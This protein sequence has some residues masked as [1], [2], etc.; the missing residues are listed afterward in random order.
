VIEWVFYE[1][2]VINMIGENIRKAGFYLTDFLKGSPVAQHY[3][4][5]DDKMNGRKDS[6]DVMPDLLKYVKANIPYY[7]Y[8]DNLELLNFP[9]VKKSDMVADFDAFQSPE[10]AETDLHWV[11]TSGT[12]GMPFK[13]S[14]NPDKRNRTIADLIYFH[15][16]AGWDVGDRYVFLRAWTSDYIVH[17]SKM[18]IQNFIPFDLI[19]FDDEAKEA[20]KQILVTDKKVKVLLGYSSGMENF[21][22]YLEDTDC[23]SSIFN[24]KVIIVDTDNLTDLTKRKLENMFACPVINRYSNE[25]QGILATTPPYNEVFRLNTAS[26]Y[27]ELLKL[28]SDEPAG[29]GEIGR[30]VVT[31]LYNRSMPFIRFDTGDLAISNDAD[32][33]HLKTISSLEGRV[34]D[35]I[36]DTKGNIVTTA[37]VCSYMR[38]FEKFKKYQLIQDEADHYL[39]K[40]VCDEG[41]YSD[42]VFVETLHKV[43]GTNANIDVEHVD[44]IASEKT[45]KY[46]TVRNLYTK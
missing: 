29:P 11:Y 15:K 22:N 37:I 36:R 31:D 21:V 42:D 28:N 33:Q 25:E 45:G 1:Q 30:I 12:T 41:A 38:E 43:L 10:F 39:L 35:S 18:F 5:I 16:L 32:R 8:I 7:A 20:M 2:E 40:V 3:K 19:N 9:V 26:Y 27:F 44:N 17:K 46:K 13:A 14:Q 23:D 34:T 6:L 24:I 4:D